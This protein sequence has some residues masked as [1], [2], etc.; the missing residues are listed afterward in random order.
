MKIKAKE[1]KRL[2]ERSNDLDTLLN[3]SMLSKYLVME[4]HKQEKQIQDLI[5][6]N[7]DRC[8]DECNGGLPN[9]FYN[10]IKNTPIQDL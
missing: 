8:A 4:K 9:G 1:Y 2:V 5:W 6:L 3:G 7:S 10:L